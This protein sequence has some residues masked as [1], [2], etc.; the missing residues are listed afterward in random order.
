MGGGGGGGVGGGGE[1]GRRGGGEEGIQVKPTRG[2][3]SVRGISLKRP[4]LCF[5][6]CS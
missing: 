4:A 1:G 6:V 3:M 2:E 5:I